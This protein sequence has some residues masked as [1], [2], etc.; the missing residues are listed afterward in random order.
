MNADKLEL[1]ISEI[2]KRIDHLCDQ[3]ASSEN[4]RAISALEGACACCYAARQGLTL[5]EYRA[6][7]REDD[8][9]PRA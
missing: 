6:N 9:C 1:A 8:A 5:A 7:Q 3:R 2:E 4:N